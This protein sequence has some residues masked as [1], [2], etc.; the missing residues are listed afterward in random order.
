MDMRIPPL[1]DNIMLESNSPKSNVSREIGRN[2]NNTNHDTNTGNNTNTNNSNDNVNADNNN[3]NKNI[4]IS[5][6]S[7]IIM[8]LSLLSLTK[9][10]WPPGSRRSSV[11]GR[12]RSGLAC[13]A[14]LLVV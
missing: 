5:I 10:A 7:I 6:I 9:T 12:A 14:F 13:L 3:N 4:L 8:I 2:G 11:P 1:T